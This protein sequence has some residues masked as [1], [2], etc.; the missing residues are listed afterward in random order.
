VST[1]PPAGSGRVLDTSALVSAATGKH[2]YARALIA[3][4]LHSGTV[5]LLIPV[6]AYIQALAILP[7]DLRWQL[8]LLTTSPTVDINYL[9]DR[10]KAHEAADLAVADVALAHVAWC[11]LR[12]GW[13]IVTDRGEELRAIAPGVEI[14]PLP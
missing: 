14:E 13:Q 3:A 8:M 10:E 5:T 12:Y 1:F 11:G 6:S 7:Q 2:L 4:S 9:E